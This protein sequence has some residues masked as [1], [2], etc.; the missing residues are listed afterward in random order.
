MQKLIDFSRL[1]GSD[2]ELVIAGGG[3]TSM[4]ENG[5]LHVKRSGAALATVSAADFVA[6]DMA[7]LLAVLER[8][9]PE[10][11]REREAA[12]LADV[13]DARLPGQEHKRPS[14]EALLHALFPKRY[15]LHLHPALVNGL[16][17]SVNGENAAGEMFPDAAWIAECKP[18]YMLAKQLAGK[19]GRETDTVLLQNHGVFFASDSAEGLHTLLT[20]MLGKLAEAVAENAIAQTK[21][22]SGC[23]EPELGR[24]FTPDQIVYCGTGPTLPDTK[25]A[26]LLFDDA[27][28]ITRYAESFGG[29]LPM[30]PELVEFI[31]N[32]EAENYRKSK[33]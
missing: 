14:V 13:L 16:T 33:S 28:K 2:P 6:M 18:G 7:A 31:A 9:Y 29:A 1:Y 4:K 8:A 19:L 27:R 24:P 25:N 22:H 26:R 32:W 11:D 17:C 12:C 23:A 30:S 5:V 3:N 15:V 20:D 21:A 10:G